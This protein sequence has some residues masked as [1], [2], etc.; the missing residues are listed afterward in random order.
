MANTGRK[1]YPWLIQVDDSGM[2]TGLRKP[3]DP[4]DPDYVAPIVDYVDCPLP[5]TTTTTST[6]TTTTALPAQDIEFKMTDIGVTSVSYKVSAFD[7]P[8]GV[9]YFTNNGVNI[10]LPTTVFPLGT[11]SLASLDLL[12]SLNSANSFD[13]NVEIFY[14]NDSGAT[15]T[16]LGSFNMKPAQTVSNIYT[17]SGVSSLLDTNMIDIRVQKI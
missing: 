14:S 6:T 17:I 8:S 9:N 13:T 1:I 11:Y 4:S 12:I 5:T 3:N 2:P 15:F 7:V 10:L 16:S